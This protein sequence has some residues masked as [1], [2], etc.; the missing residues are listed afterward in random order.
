M[1]SGEGNSGA[2]GRGGPGRVEAGTGARARATDPAPGGQNPGGGPGARR[3]GREAAPGGAGPRALLR[4]GRGRASVPASEVSAL[5]VGGPGPRVCCL[6]TYSGGRPG[7]AR[8]QAPF[9][10]RAAG[11]GEAFLGRPHQPPFTPCSR[12]AVRPWV[13]KRAQKPGLSGTPDRTKHSKAGSRSARKNPRTVT[14]CGVLE[15]SEEGAPALGSP[16]GR[17]GSPAPDSRVTTSPRRATPGSPGPE[18]RACLPRG[19]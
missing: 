11:P 2:R 18:P 12:P 10:P 8:L 4:A 9:L 6:N 17:G 15:P 1:G 13:W 14:V 5:G 16:R 19:W 3:R 7:E